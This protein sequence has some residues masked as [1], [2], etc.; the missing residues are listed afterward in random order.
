LSSADR[1]H[2]LFASGFVPI[3]RPSVADAL[4]G[5]RRVFCWI[6]GMKDAVTWLIQQ[7]KL[8]RERVEAERKRQIAALVA[9]E[10]KRNGR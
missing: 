3:S 6:H 8:E 9:W 7:A 10:A 5:G 4:L 2:N 1:T